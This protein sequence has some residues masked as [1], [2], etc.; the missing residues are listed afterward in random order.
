MELWLP[1][2]GVAL[3]GIMSY[4]VTALGDR[5][6]NET[7]TLALWREKRLTSYAEFLRDAKRVRV[8]AQRVASAMGLERNAPP[9]PREEGLRL[10][11]EAETDR[12]LI[13]ELV[14]LLGS[15]ETVMAGRELNRTLWALERSVRGSSSEVDATRWTEAMERHHRAVDTFNRCARRDLGIKGPYQDRPAEDWPVV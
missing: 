7:A 6:R 15:A 13:F 2:I 3:G 11:A 5:Q 12:T 8:M 14:S 1:L 4:G 10:L 9:L